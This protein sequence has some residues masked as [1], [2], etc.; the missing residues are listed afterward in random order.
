MAHLLEMIDGKGQMFSVKQKPWHEL[1]IILDNPPTSEEA[2]VAAGLD[3]TVKK[4]ET[5]YISNEQMKDNKGQYAIVR[6]KDNSLL[7]HS[8]ENWQ[9]LQNKDAFK[10]FDPFIQAGE[11]TYETA[12]SLENGKRIWVLAKINKDPLEIVKGDTVEKFILLSNTHSGGFA[13][14][15]GLTP[16]RVVCNNTLKG[17]MMSSKSRLFRATHSKQMITRLEDL[18][19]D[20]AQA[21]AAFKMAGEAYRKFAKKQ[22]NKSTFDQFMAQTFQWSTG[23]V[24][25]S[26][27][28][29][30][31]QKATTATIE[32]LMEIGRGADIKG[33]QGTIWGAYNA[34]TEYVQHEQGKADTRLNRA[35]FGS[36]NNLNQRAFEAAVSV[37]A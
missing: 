2:I 17:A 11:A 31:I 21:D 12:G 20:I 9:P 36:G 32:R 18:Q 1:G 19:A 25:S 33:V 7:G 5:F 15:G 30:T 4:H 29:E 22:L 10:F 37:A 8:G 23:G 24:H 34:V 16:I 27:R 28:D 35:W 26:K 6:E 14:T 13:V 3:W